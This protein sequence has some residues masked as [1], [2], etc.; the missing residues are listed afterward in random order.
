MQQQKVPFGVDPKTVLCVFFKAGSCL[1]GDKCKFS[2]DASVE[3]KAAKINLYQDQ[4]DKNDEAA[5][6]WDD[7]RLAEITESHEP[8]A[9]ATTG[10]I[11]NYFMDAVEQHKYG[12]FW[13]C[14]NGEKCQYRH[15]LPPGFVL[16]SK[17]EKKAEEKEEISLEDF[18]ETERH[19]IK[20][21]IPV[22]AESFAKWKADRKT[23]QAAEEAKK[24][25]ARETEARAGR[26]SHMSGRDLFTYQPD[27][28]LGDDDNEA[29]EVDYTARVDEEDEGAEEHGEVDAEVFMDE[30]LENLEID[31]D[32]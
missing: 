6:G 22:T 19:K 10:R 5:E 1:K 8:G 3:R 13:E 16:R 2:H 24:A 9:K 32:E 7:A 4:R 30:S 27:L 11:C 31:E 29:M 12:W 25:K 26:L 18:L 14:P 21:T 15:A 20:K 23:K 28:F 17:D